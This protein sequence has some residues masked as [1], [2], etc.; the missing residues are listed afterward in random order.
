MSERF[1]KNRK[2]PG[3]REQSDVIEIQSLAG[4]VRKKNAS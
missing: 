3:K 1:S 4:K 2:E